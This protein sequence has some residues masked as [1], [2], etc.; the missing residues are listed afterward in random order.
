MRFGIRGA[1]TRAV[2]IFNLSRA[3][4]GGLGLY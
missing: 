2:P 4:M 3:D 1:S